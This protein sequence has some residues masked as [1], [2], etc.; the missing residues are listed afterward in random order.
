MLKSPHQTSLH[1]K[2]LVSVLVSRVW[3]RAT[4]LPPTRHCPLS[5][6]THSWVNPQLTHPLTPLYTDPVYRVVYTNLLYFVVMFLVPLAVLLI[7]NGELIRV[8]RDKKAK[9]AQL[10]QGRTSL[11]SVSALDANSRCAVLA[12]PT[13]RL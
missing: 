3:P 12:P 2:L 7:L 5:K 8:L 13:A 4:S 6:R 11:A 9:R 10:L 1:T